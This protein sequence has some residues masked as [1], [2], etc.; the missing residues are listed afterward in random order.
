MPPD[1][2]EDAL[3]TPDPVQTAQRLARAKALAVRETRPEGFIIA[4]DTVVAIEMDG[5]DVQLGKPRDEAD[6]LRILRVLQGETHTVTT[7]VALAWPGGF[8]AFT[9]SSR[10][11]FRAVSDE[12]LKAYIATGEPMDKAGAYGLQG[13][14]KGFLEKI[15][16]SVSCVIGL[17]MER[18]REA[19]ESIKY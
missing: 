19:L 11:T 3:T 1:L 16:G 12:E 4:A 13:G 2:D 15:E 14:A 6:A 17:P 18:L 9:E 10:V 5:Q 7:G 8:S